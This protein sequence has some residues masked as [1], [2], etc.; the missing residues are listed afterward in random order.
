MPASSGKALVE[1]VS[2]T[3]GRD[4][5]PMRRGAGT[6]GAALGSP[7]VATTSDAAFMLKDGSTH[8]G[9]TGGASALGGLKG[10][11]MGGTLSGEGS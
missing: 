10:G 3:S 6:F 4:A 7:M 8:G 11:V 9:V 2:S 1:R 5:M